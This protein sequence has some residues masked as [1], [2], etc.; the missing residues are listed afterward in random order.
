MQSNIF[1]LAIILFS[2]SSYSF[3]QELND[4]F[5]KSLP[6]NIASDLM[7]RS[8]E[9]ESN[10]EVQYRRPSTFI[11]KPEPTSERFGAQVF[12][13]MQT[14]LMPINEPNFDSSYVLDFGDEV[15]IQLIGQ[16]SLTKKIRIRGDGSINLDDIGKIYLA[17]LPLKDASDLI[18]AKVNNTFI[19]VEAFLTLVNVRNIQI[20]VVGNAYNPGPYTLNGNTNIFHALSVSGGPSEYGSFRSINL[21]RN[22]KII[23]NVDLYDAFIYGKYNF[24]TRLRSGDM[25]FINPVGKVITINGAVKR[26]GKYELI[27]GE[28]AS[29]ALSFAN[30][31][32][33]FADIYGIKLERIINGKIKQLPIINLEQLNEINIQDTDMIDIRSFSFRSIEISGAVQNPGIYLMNEGDNMFDAIKKA[34]GYTDS[35][36]PFGGVYESREAQ[37]INEMAAEEL[38][39]DLLDEIISLQQSD[40][41]KT[42]PISRDSIEMTEELKDADITGRVIADFINEDQDN[43]IFVKDGDKITIP[44]LTNQVYVYGEIASEGAALYSDGEGVQYYINKKGGLKKSAEKKSIYVLHPNGESELLSRNRNIFVNQKNKNVKIYPGSI[45]FIPRDIDNG[46]NATMRAQ[47]IATIIGN[48]GVSLASLSV[49]SDRP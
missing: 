33:S 46:L 9:S 37:E 38:Y 29:T 28:N 8:Q 2:I 34:G 44:E 31:L 4:S 25:V 49:L 16:K 47:S 10:D 1:K 14:T 21:I 22:N 39:Q 15:E 30:G 26:P 18:K 3:A 23:E 20:L 48:I 11:K 32:N 41:T 12:S 35:A 27:E 19:G 45:I 43:P 36:Y 24:N 7:K 17:G 5:L 42:A 40:V 13:M 6:D